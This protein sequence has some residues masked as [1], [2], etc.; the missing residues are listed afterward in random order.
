LYHQHVKK[1]LVVCHTEA[2]GLWFISLAFLLLSLLFTGG[3]NRLAN[4]LFVQEVQESTS[5]NVIC[6]IT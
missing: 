2:G 5:M 4:D 1:S 6:A 3:S